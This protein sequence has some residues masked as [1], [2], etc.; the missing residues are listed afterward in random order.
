MQPN[1]KRELGFYWIMGKQDN[2]K[3]PYVCEYA[4]HEKAYDVFRAVDLST[5]YLYGWKMDEISDGE[6]LFSDKNIIVLS[7]RLIPPEVK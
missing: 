7:E 4:M 6:H 2:T 1:Q 3:T 5:T